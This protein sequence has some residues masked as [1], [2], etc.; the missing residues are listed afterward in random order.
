MRRGRVLLSG[1]VILGG[2][3]LLQGCMT[4]QWS[5]KDKTEKDAAMDLNDCE[6]KVHAS[7]GGAARTDALKHMAASDEIRKCMQARGYVL[8]Y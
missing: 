5:A 8:V 3:V 2:L 1:L 4:G 6:L 7:Y